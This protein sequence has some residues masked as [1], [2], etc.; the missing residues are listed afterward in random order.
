[1][2]PLLLSLLL[3]AAASAQG[4]LAF[5][6]ETL[7]FGR[8]D[9]ADGSVE[10]TF[11]FSNAGDAPLRLARVQAACG[12]TTPSWTDGEVAPGASGTIEVAYDPTGRP[13]PFDKP[14]YVEAEGAE[15]V[16]L[17]ITG[18]VRPALAERGVRVGAL[19]FEAV[20]KDVGTIPAGEPLQT[21]LQFANV[22]ERPVRVERVEAPAGVEVSTSDRPIAP[23]MLGG[24]FVSV[25]NPAAH[26]AEDRVVVDLVLHTTDPEEP[27]K[28]VRVTGRIGP[29]IGGG[30]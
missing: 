24:L 30:E 7:D 28:R 11:R 29:A 13:G 4:R 15:A 18:V 9:E 3:A 16:Y 5:E 27:V 1:M 25:E 19:A 17:Q 10:R 8:I 2:R 20:E 6:A 23:D 14:I 12:C 21:G 22:G 26:S